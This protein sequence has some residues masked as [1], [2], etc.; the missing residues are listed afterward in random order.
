MTTFASS[1]ILY[2]LNSLSIV[3]QR[4]YLKDFQIPQLLS[5]VNP[6]NLGSFI[7]FTPF[8]RYPTEGNSGS[9]SHANRYS[10]E[11]IKKHFPG[12]KHKEA[13]VKVKL[14]MITKEY[15]IDCYKLMFWLNTTETFQSMPMMLIFFFLF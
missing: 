3:R 12:L 15:I 7:P 4:E 14:N 10:E 11:I 9:I 2:L 8:V 6:E 1:D 13:L 5:T